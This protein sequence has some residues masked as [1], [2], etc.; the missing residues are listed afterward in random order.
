MTTTQTAAT[1]E[2]VCCPE[3]DGAGH[4]WPASTKTYGGRAVRCAMCRGAKR[5]PAAQLRAMMDN[6]REAT[7]VRDEKTLATLRVLYARARRGWNDSMRRE[8]ADHLAC[9]SA[10]NGSYIVETH[11]EKLGMVFGG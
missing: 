10:S 1:V 6:D 8:V 4:T 9:L 5:I 7:E 3:C 2:T 11:F